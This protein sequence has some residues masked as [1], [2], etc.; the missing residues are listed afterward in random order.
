[1]AGREIKTLL[2]VPPLR[3]RDIANEPYPPIGLSYIAACLEENG[4]GVR[5]LDAFSEG[6]ENIGQEGDYFT[7]GLPEEAIRERLLEYKP[8][9]VGI[10]W[11]F[12]NFFDSRL[13]IADLVKS[14]LPKCLVVLGGAHVTMEY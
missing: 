6:R 1:M 3:M 5:I 9:I 4:F 11:N 8:D 7:V 2:M 12:T 14:T 13:Q 10:S